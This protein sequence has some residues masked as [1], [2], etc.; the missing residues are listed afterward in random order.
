MDIWVIFNSLYGIG[1]CT[2]GELRSLKIYFI[3]G[4]TWINQWNTFQLKFE[5]KK[6]GRG[7]HYVLDWSESL[8]FRHLWLLWLEWFVLLSLPHQTLIFWE[9]TQRH[10]ERFNSPLSFSLLYSVS[11]TLCRIKI[12][13]QKC[14][15]NTQSK[16]IFV[17]VFLY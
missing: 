1:L 14:P 16:G 2:Y 11:S 5:N 7:K 4:E 10:T 6:T 15:C 9:H 3:R 12:S 8:S 17:L 13:L